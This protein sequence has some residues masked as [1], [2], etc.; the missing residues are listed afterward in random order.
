M[1][2]ALYIQNYALIDKLEIAFGQGFTTITGETGAGKSILLGALSLVLGQRVD[3]SVLLDKNRKCIVE[4]TFQVGN[5]R[6]KPYFEANEIDYD[7]QT[8]VRRII[9]PA[10]KSRAFINDNPV[11]ISLLKELGKKMLDIHSQHQNL[12][13]NDNSFRLTVLDSIA[14]QLDLL[15]DYQSEFSKLK[16]LSREHKSLLAKAEAAKTEADYF[17]FQYKQL[18]EAA[19]QENEQEEAENQLDTLNHAEEIKQ[20][21]AKAFLLLSEENEFAILNRLQEIDSLF[22]RIA[23]FFPKAEALN[24]R[25]DSAYIELKDIAEELETQAGDIEYNPQEIE[26]LNDRLNLIYSLQQKHRVSTCAELI[27]KKAFFEQKLSEINS[28][29]LQLDKLKRQVQKQEEQVN[30]LAKTISENRRKLIPQVEKNI[31]E[32]LRHLGMPEADFKVQH[33]YLP[34]AQSLGIDDINFLFT[35]NKELDLQEITKIASGGELSRIMLSLKYLISQSV[36]LPSIIFDEIDTGVSG[37]IANK[38]GNIMQNLAKKMQVISITHLPQ[39]AA[40]G[41]NHFLVYKN[42]ATEK[43]HTNI[44][45]LTKKERVTEIAKMLSGEDITR[46]ALNNAKELLKG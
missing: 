37:D 6:L 31:A 44:R 21:L 7:E 35:S 18:E 25:I 41:D 34:Q 43:T 15:H 14:A 20:N 1:L 27:E 46:A 2:T 16:E 36:A 22:S 17:Q 10:G 30:K 45:Q 13:L 3:T 32:Q 42:S 24:A 26:N 12:L 23:G 4:A 40:K 28:F 29:D 8:I 5:Y 19:I 9:S 39:I 33:A 11:K 38:M